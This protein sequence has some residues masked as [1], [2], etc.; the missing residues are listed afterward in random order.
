MAEPVIVHLSDHHQAG[1]GYYFA[2]IDNRGKW[3]R[4]SKKALMPVGFK[5]ISCSK[6]DKPAIQLDHF[7]PYEC[8]NN[9]C[10]DHMKRKDEK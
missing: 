6:C 10:E 9:L 1:D 2:D 3:F 7:Y 8:E 4:V 5:A